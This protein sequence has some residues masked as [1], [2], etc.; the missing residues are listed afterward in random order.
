MSW[1]TFFM[2]IC[3]YQQCR[4]KYFSCVIEHT[5]PLPTTPE[6]MSPHYLVKCKTFFHLTECSVVFLQTLVALKRAGC[7][8]WKME[9]QASNVTA[10]VQ[11]DHLLHTDTCFH[12]FSTL[13]NWIVHH[14][15]LKFRPRRNKTLPQL[16]R[17]ADWYSITRSC[18][19]P[20]TR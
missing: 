20:Q 14:A 18:S 16:V 17:V 6:K 15:L 5:N 12:S 11:S 19:M 1:G 4:P 8:V 7:D 9:C 3:S 10:S 2:V 13:I